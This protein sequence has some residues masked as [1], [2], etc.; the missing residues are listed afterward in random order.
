MV[1]NALTDRLVMFR[2]HRPV[3]SESPMLIVCPSCATSYQVEPESLGQAGRSV[4][5][6]RCQHV[7]FATIPSL[8]SAGSDEWDV[9]D[10]G[11]RVPSVDSTRGAFAPMQPSDA[12]APSVEGIDVAGL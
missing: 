12:T 7:W 3:C 1:S 2:A 5:C 10:T 6:A 8:I 4:R 11:P 9:I